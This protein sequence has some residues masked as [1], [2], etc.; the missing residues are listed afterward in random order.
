MCECKKKKKKGTRW[1]NIEE[2]K[3]QFNVHLSTI[4]LDEHYIA[5]MYNTAA[6]DEI[7]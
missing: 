6:K 1:E 3:G 7:I 2:K 4:C 5:K